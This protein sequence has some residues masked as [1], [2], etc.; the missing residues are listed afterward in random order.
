[1]STSDTGGEPHARVDVLRRFGERFGFFCHGS[2][3][4]VR[5]FA[6]AGTAAAVVYLPSLGIQY[7][8][9]CECEQ[10]PPSIVHAQ[11]LQRREL[12]KRLDVLYETRPQ[13]SGV[14][15][16]D[17]IRAQLLRISTP[18]RAPA[19]SVGFY[20]EPIGIDRLSL[21]DD[22]VHDRRLFRWS[23]GAW[24]ESVLMP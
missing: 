13:G 5:E 8:A 1:L 11:W 23:D 22:G 9:A 2:G 10:I 20:L 24:S 15:S 16:L 6:N 21:A 3:S 12:S 18:E 19:T 4:K 17:W 7:R 14:E